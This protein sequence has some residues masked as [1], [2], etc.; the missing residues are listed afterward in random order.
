VLHALPFAFR[1]Q[2]PARQRKPGAH[3]ASFAHMERHFVPA[4]VKGLQ[5]RAAGVEH[6]PVA[7]HVAAGVYR[8]MLQLSPAQ[9][10]PAV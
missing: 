3:C 10:V 5:L 1:P 6:W 9:V 2:V 7:V 4:Q 8:P